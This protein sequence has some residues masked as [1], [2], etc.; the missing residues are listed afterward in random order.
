M[1]ILHLSAVDS[2]H[3]AARSS[4]YLNNSNSPDVLPLN[5]NA[6]VEVGAGMAL[7]PFVVVLDMDGRMRRRNGKVGIN[8]GRV[9]VGGNG[10]CCFVGGVGRAGVKRGVDGCGCDAEAGDGLGGEG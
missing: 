10:A 4:R 1:I 2:E 3:S 6:F 5:V 7:I 8:A 9:L